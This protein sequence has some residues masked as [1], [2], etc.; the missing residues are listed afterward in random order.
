MSTK[1]THAWTETTI[2]YARRLEEE[3]LPN[4]ERIVAAALQLMED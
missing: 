4:V 2:P 3:T 1:A